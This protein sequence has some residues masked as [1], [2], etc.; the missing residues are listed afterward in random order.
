MDVMRGATGQTEKSIHVKLPLASL[1][2]VSLLRQLGTCY[3]T[4]SVAPGKAALNMA[5]RPCWIPTSP[6]CLR[7]LDR[8]L[9]LIKQRDVSAEIFGHLLQNQI[10]FFLFVFLFLQLACAD[11]FKVVC[12]RS[13]KSICSPPSL[14]EV[15]TL[16]WKRFQCSS[17]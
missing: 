16:P 5:S 14:S 7:S 6:S 9:V 15:S 1:R 3:V 10:D 2:V 4:R 13:E 17:L 8:F 12:M 11:H